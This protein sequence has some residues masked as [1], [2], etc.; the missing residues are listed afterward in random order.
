MVPIV[1]P[2]ASESARAEVLLGFERSH[3]DREAVLHIGLEQSLVGFVDLL[4]RDDF[5][6]GGDV[7]RATKVEHLLSLWDTSDW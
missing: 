2:A 1:S 3:I 5:D 4:N 6:V 7:M